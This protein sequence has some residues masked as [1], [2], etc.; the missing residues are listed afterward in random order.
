MGHAFWT[1]PR[2]RALRGRFFIRAFGGVSNVDI[3]GNNAI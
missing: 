2:W 3:D 1:S